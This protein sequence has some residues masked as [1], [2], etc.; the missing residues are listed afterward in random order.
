MITTDG[1][2]P[3]EGDGPK[4][5]RMWPALDL[6]AS[7]QPRWLAKDRI[8][9]AAV[10]LI[11]GE[12]GIGKSLLWVW[13]V[14]IIT[15][16]KAAPAFGIPARAPGA[17]IIAAITEDDW[18][19]VVRP[20]LEAAKA[21]LS[22]IVVICSEEDGSGTPVFPKDL[23]LIRKWEHVCDLI[24]VDAWL[25]TVPY[26]LN[27]RDTQQARM[28]LHPWK[29]LA[30][31][32]DAAVLLV[33]HTNRV[34]TANARDRYGATIALRQKARMTL[35]CLNGDDLLIVGP[36]KANGTAI[37]NASMFATR[38]VQL[39]DATL[40]H[41]GIVP[42]LVPDGVSDQTIKAYIAEEYANQ[43]SANSAKTDGSDVVAWLA[44]ALRDGPR[45][46]QEVVE[47][48]K[49]FSYT[50]DQLKKAKPKLGARSE[51]DQVANA[52]FWYLPG[53]QGPPR[54]QGCQP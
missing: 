23:E 44:S 28:A 47:A 36:E 8:P 30:T 24:V 37:V 41:D 13:L 22:K 9:R 49:A 46:Q 53:Q 21:D 19:T 45:W 1:A 2:N 39:F 12:E 34:S 40:E 14:A 20:R 10:S 42:A 51:R 48:A 7:A 33:C 16:G 31:A 52:W 3:M 18:R 54:E 15:T 4:P 32:T 29:E 35:Y 11:I 50:I 5:P 25:D 6:K 43:R 27:V 26:D 38:S 17:V